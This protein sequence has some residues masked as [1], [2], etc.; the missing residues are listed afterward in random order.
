MAK[1]FNALVFVA[2]AWVSATPAHATALLYTF[3]TTS[4]AC[5]VNIDRLCNDLSQ[6]RAGLDGM[7]IALAPSALSNGSAML[8]FQHDSGGFSQPAVNDGVSQMSLYMYIGGYLTTVPPQGFI[9]SPF[10]F[11]NFELVE[12]DIA[13]GQFLTGSMYANNGSSDISM[14]TLQGQNEWSGRIRSDALSSLTIG[15]TGNWRFSG[16]VP[17]PGTLALLMTGLALAAALTRRRST[18]QRLSTTV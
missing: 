5:E 8:K 7:S 6:E 10:L 2:C 4:I 11:Q 1:I 9:F 3:Q 14:S 18:P 12:I 16:V 13:L 15:F 17:E